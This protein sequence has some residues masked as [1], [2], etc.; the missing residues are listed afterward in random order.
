MQRLAIL[1][2]GLAGLSLAYFLTKNMK[3]IY[4]DI[5]EKESVVGGLCR[6]FKTS[7]IYWDIGPHIIFSKNKEILSLM[8]E[9]L[10]DNVLRVKR[11]NQIFYNKK[12]IKYPFENNLHQLP[13]EDCE[14]C[15]NTFLNNSYKNY[16]PHNM[17][18]FFL[19]TF[20]EGITS[21]YLEPYNKKIWEFNPVFMNTLMVERIPSPPPEDI[22]AGARRNAKEGYVHQLYFYYPKNGGIASLINNICDL[23][24]KERAKFFTNSEVVGINQNNEGNWQISLSTGENYTNYNKIVSTIP[25]TELIRVLPNVPQ[26]VT[27]ASNA[28]M[29]NS[30]AVIFLKVSSDNIGNNFSITIPDKDVLAHRISKLDFLG[31]INSNETNL[32]VEV[33]FRDKDII[34]EMS[35]E[36]L[37]E[38]IDLDLKRIGLLNESTIIL[39]AEIRRVPYAYVIY[40][41]NYQNNT[42]IIKKYLKLLGITIHGR[43]GTFEYLNMD[44]VIANSKELSEQL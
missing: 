17:L 22:I 34:S 44:Q 20:G 9:L 4:L 15:L 1:G 26:E 37:L 33:T 2:G 3:D 6:S 16:S 36:K 13:E 18:A 14:Y 8:V 41:L 40:D 30:I 28:L 29:N 25:M 42:D 31:P 39:D 24:P 7:N 19:K 21:C 38:L 10:G 11:S 23:I 27:V 12:F 43:F 35:D 32:L 5:F